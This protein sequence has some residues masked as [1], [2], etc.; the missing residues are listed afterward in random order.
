MT[1][2]TVS[3]FGTPGFVRDVAEYA[4]APQAFNEVKNARFNST[5]IQTFAGEIDVMSPAAAGFA[6]LWL[7]AFPPLDNPLW[8][9]ANNSEIYAYDGNHNQITRNSGP[10]SGSITERWHA[11]VYN[12]YGVFNNTVDVPQM[13]AD[14]DASQK[15]VDF[16]TWPSSLRCK[17]LRPWKNFLFA[18]NLSVVSGPGVGP[19]P[20]SIRWSDQVAPGVVPS[21]DIAD[22]TNKAGEVDIADTDD[23][24]IE[25]C[26]M[27]D[28]MI[29]Y[30]QKTTHA[31]RNIYPNPDIFRRDKIL[32]KGILWRDCVQNFPKGQFVV[33]LDDIYIHTGGKDSDV[34]L[35]EARLR[36]WVFNQIDAHNFFYCY[37][38][39]QPRRNEIAFAFPEAGETYPTLALVWN[40]VTNGIGVRELH[41][42]PFIYPGPILVPVEDDIWGDDTVETNYL[43]TENG[44]ALV[45]ETGDHLVW[46]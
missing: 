2:L 13:W 26:E 10:Y 15:L 38:Y 31:F 24:I 8:V 3:K 18:G 9:Y 21:W 16:T 22:P 37:T 12:G 35:V 25:A 32:S 23:H 14:F 11:D 1:R 34:S 44:D 7:K 43:V 42:S 45:T 36:E 19:K 41:K 30:K 29:V 39:Q 33:G 4:I 28:I 17:F 20:F 46:S 40:W 5:G 27:G 6:P